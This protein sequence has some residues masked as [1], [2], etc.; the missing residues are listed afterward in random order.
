MLVVHGDSRSGN[1]YKVRLLLAHLGTPFEW[2]EY[3]VTRGPT[4]TPAF[5]AMNPNGRLPLLELEDG[6]YLPESNAILW[7]LAEGTPCL[8]GDRLGRARALQWMFFEQYSHEPYIATSRYWLH[9]LGEPERYREQLEAKR[10]PAYAALAVME[11]HLAAHD[12]FAGGAFSVADIAL[13]AY[14]HVAHEG[15]FSLDAYPAVR[16]WLARVKDLPGHVAMHG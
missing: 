3:D 1:C 12:W 9:L 10:G 5:L 11:G 16:A 7:Y 15:G 4:R 13:Y 14:T 2:R 6:G 8:P